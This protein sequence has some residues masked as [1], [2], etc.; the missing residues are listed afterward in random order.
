MCYRIAPDY[1]MDESGLLIFCPRSSRSSEERIYM[2]RL[3][4]PELLQR[5]FVI[6][7]TRF[8][9]KAN[10]GSEGRISG[11]DLISIGEGYIGA[12]NHM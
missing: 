11:S 12:S 2:I 1:E 7:I 6:I 4:V 8:W 10:K 9:K 5:D 3:V